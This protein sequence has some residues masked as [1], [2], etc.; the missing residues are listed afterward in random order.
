MKAKL[1]T[2]LAVI[3][4]AFVLAMLQS[5]TPPYAMLTGP[6][7][8]AGNAASVVKST[9]FDIQIANVLKARS[10]AYDQ[11]GQAVDLQSAGVWI[12]VSTKFHSFRETMPIRAA[13]IIGASGRRYRQSQRAAGAPD[14]MATKLLQPGLPTTGILIFEMPEDETGHMTLVVSEQ[15]DPQ[16]QDEVSVALEPDDAPA[17]DRLEIGPDGV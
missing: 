4:T 17:Q 10:I 16:L 15:Y 9:T 5:T 14:V 12:V 7:K 6:I 1:R 13:T 8:T 2:I 3:A 11:F